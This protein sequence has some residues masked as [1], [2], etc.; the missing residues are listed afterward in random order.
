M[1]LLKLK[2]MH[3]KNE[4]AELNRTNDARP[5]PRKPRKCNA[6]HLQAHKPHWKALTDEQLLAGRALRAA[7]TA[8]EAKEP[9]EHSFEGE[10]IEPHQRAVLLAKLADLVKRA[11]RPYYDTEGIFFWTMKGALC[12]AKAF[13]FLWKSPWK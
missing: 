6:Q 8:P 2:Q 13:L 5:S 7:Q 10:A 4:P 11:T 9:S 1:R 3:Q 12:V